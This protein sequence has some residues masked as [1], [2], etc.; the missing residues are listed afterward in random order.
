MKE[1]SR[2]MKQYDSS[3]LANLND[4]DIHTLTNCHIYI[5]IY[6]YANSRKLSSKVKKGNED[7]ASS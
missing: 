7:I 5:Y 6:I 4:K 1:N 2:V 3:V